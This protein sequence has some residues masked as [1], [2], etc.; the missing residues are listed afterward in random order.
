[1]VSFIISSSVF[2]LIV[3]LLRC[4]CHKHISMRLQY[5]LWLLVAIKLLIFPV[6]WIESNFSIF[7][8]PDKLESM[9]DRRTNDFSAEKTTIAPENIIQQEYSNQAVQN[10]NIQ[11]KENPI[12]EINPNKIQNSNATFFGHMS[13]QAVLLALAV[14][15][16]C[17][18]FIFWIITNLKFWRY[19]RKHRVNVTPYKIDLP[20]EMKLKI[21]AVPQLPTPCLYGKAI[22]MTRTL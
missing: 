12:P 7:N 22:Y 18:F 2:I 17:I 5:M 6:P 13:L 11:N 20:F 1:M 16:A 15:G 8:I 4:L 21:Y 9:T 19:L 10:N 14:T 3:I